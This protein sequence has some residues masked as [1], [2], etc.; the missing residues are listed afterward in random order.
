MLAVRAFDISRLLRRNR[1]RARIIFAQH[2]C[3][4]LCNTNVFCSCPHLQW[5]NKLC[6]RAFF[7]IPKLPEPN[8]GGR[9]GH[10]KSLTE[11]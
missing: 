9:L 8:Y 7:Q 10:A 5:I 1:L 6:I 4:R 2:F 11:K 3:G